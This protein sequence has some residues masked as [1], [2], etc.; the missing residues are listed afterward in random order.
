MNKPQLS[1]AERLKKGAIFLSQ[2]WKVP[3][4]R[5]TAGWSLDVCTCVPLKKFCNARLL[6]IT[7]AVEECRDLEEGPFGLAAAMTAREWDATGL[8]MK[9]EH[10]EVGVISIGASQDCVTGMVDMGKMMD[11]PMVLAS[12]LRV[13]RAFPKS[14]VEGLEGEVAAPVVIDVVIPVEANPDEAFE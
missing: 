13:L 11:A 12:T 6:W 10:S 5:C 9:I 1:P 4:Q 2:L 14:R 7:L 3:E 8:T